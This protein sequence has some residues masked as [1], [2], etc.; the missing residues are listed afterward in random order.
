MDGLPKSVWISLSHAE[1]S[2]SNG[3]TNCQ[4]ILTDNHFLL[5]RAG[6]KALRAEASVRVTGN[7]LE[8]TVQT[9]QFRSLK[10]RDAISAKAGIQLSRG[11]T[12]LRCGISELPNRPFCPLFKGKTFLPYPFPP[13]R[14]EEK[15]IFRRHRGLP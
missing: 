9:P 8:K 11:K 13:S 5:Q 10:Q 3:I 7:N 6:K 1:A 15:R 14:Y 2:R 12:F 4:G